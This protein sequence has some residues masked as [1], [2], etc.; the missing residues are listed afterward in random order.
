M[1]ADNRGF[2]VHSLAPF[3]LGSRLL[4]WRE[5][6]DGLSR[7]S[8]W[9]SSH[10]RNLDCMDTVKCGGRPSGRRPRKQP[11]RTTQCSSTGA[12]K[13]TNVPTGRCG[14]DIGRSHSTRLLDLC[15]HCYF[16][17]GGIGTR[18]CRR[19]TGEN[20]TNSFRRS[21]SSSPN[22][23]LPAEASWSIPFYR[24]PK[25]PTGRDRFQ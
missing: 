7:I 4:G 6:L 11:D 16:S 13:R 21:T 22:R 23:N 5:N 3:K 10:Y 17:F 18:N 9:H 8:D 19:R 14:S 2:S 15:R 24:R 1:G 12:R 20:R 25:P